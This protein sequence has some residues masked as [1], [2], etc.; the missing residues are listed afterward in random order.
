MNKIRKSQLANFLLMTLGAL[1]MAIGIY[2]FKFPNHFSTGGV[3][4]ISMLLGAVSPKFSSGLIMLI[5]NVSLL[6]LGFLLIGK[7]FGNKTVYCSMILSCVTYGLEWS[8]PRAAPLT[9]NRLFELI[10]AILLPA[11]GSALLFNLGASTGG[12]DIVAMIIKKY[13]NLNISKALMCAD[14]IIVM[15]S[16]FVFGLETWLYCLLGF[17]AKVMVVNNVIESLN[18]SKYFTIITEHEALICNF[19]TN[20]LHKD[21]TISG[22]YIGAFSQKPKSV[23]L[24]LVNRSQALA[25]KHFLNQTDP[26]ACV[27]INSTCDVIGKGFREE[28]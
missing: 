15:L 14:A 22:S 20:R 28:I 6:L 17:F 26:H 9:D 4:G 23:I 7:Y 16:I 12:T 3:S 10:F 1:L 11:I 8:A 13:T 27:I 24:T 19:I 5:I 21:A 2:F 25:L 18:T